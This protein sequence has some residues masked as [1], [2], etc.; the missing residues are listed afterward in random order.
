MADKGGDVFDKV[1]GAIPDESQQGH[2]A[3]SHF[4]SAPD[5]SG[6]RSRDVTADEEFRD[7]HSAPT[8][9]VPSRSEHGKWSDT[10]CTSSP[11]HNGSRRSQSAESVVESGRHSQKRERRQ[12]PLNQDKSCQSKSTFD[13]SYD[14]Q[15]R[16]DRRRRRRERRERKEARYEQKKEKRRN[17]RRSDRS[18]GRSP[19]ISPPEDDVAVPTRS[20]RRFSHL[21][22]TARY[23]L[24][25]NDLFAAERAEKAEKEKK[26]WASKL[27]SLLHDDLAG[28]WDDFGSASRGGMGGSNWSEDAAWEEEIRRMR[29]E[30]ESAKSGP[31]EDDDVHIPKRWRDAAKG[32]QQVRTDLM[33]DEEYAE[34]IRGELS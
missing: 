32:Q 33:D 23:G 28:G 12:D 22:S 6:S 9:S 4:G 7:F 31:M 20:S 16:R 8:Q 27:S 3:A 13:S 21:P 25:P 24:D 1:F 14:Q 15:E 30:E 11:R 26:A 34:Y 18:H 10:H 19:S 17:R 5:G 29:G 2:S